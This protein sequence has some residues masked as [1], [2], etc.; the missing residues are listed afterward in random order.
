MSIRS[1]SDY[2]LYSSIRLSTSATSSPSGAQLILENGIKAGGSS[3]SDR[4][5]GVVQ[6]PRAV[7]TEVNLDSGKSSRPDRLDFDW[8]IQ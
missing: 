6:R 5:F 7:I 8:K 1:S 3:R 2:C 4:F